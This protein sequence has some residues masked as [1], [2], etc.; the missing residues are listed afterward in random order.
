M[1]RQFFPS[2]MGSLRA[3]GQ[4]PGIWP[5][6]PIVLGRVVLAVLAI[7]V[8]S[9][10]WDSGSPQAA[11]SAP[12]SAPNSASTGANIALPERAEPFDFSAATIDIGLKLVAVLALAYVAL[13]VL[14]RH[15][16]GIAGG[17]GSQLQVLES[18][19]LAPN[20]SVYLVRA[21]SKRL[22]L[23]VTTGQITTLAELDE[24]V[25]VTIQA[26]P[27]PGSPATEDHAEED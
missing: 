21:G 20:R 10:A 3:T 7:V 18:T 5:I 26:I 16:A 14:K 25:Q 27:A 23:G 22:V 2:T 13:T 15:V 4:I 6:S 1:Q 24:P 8:L 9:L 19:T 12:G 17:R 11:S